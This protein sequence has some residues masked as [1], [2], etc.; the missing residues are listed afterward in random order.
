MA[1]L[2]E[3]LG[4]LF[5]LKRR[6]AEG[7]YEEQIREVRMVGTPGK[8]PRW[9]AKNQPQGY[10][11]GVTPGFA[12]FE[13]G[14][15]RLWYMGLARKITKAARLGFEFTEIDYEALSEM[16]E[17]NLADQ[18]KRIRE[19]EQIEFGLHMPVAARWGEVDLCL[20]DAFWWRFMHEAVRKSAWSAATFGSKFILF[21][22]SSRMRPNVTFKI[23]HR[24]APSPQVSHDGINLGQFM[25]EV[26][27]GTY[28]D[29]KR[30][31]VGAFPLKEWFMAKFMRV[32]F[33]AMGVAGDVGM[34]T[35]FEE[36][37]REKKMN[38]PEAKKEAERRY[39]DIRG[40]AWEK[41]KAE[42]IAVYN[43]EIAKSQAIIDTIEAKVPR[44]QWPG[45]HEYRS[46]KAEIASYQRLIDTLQ[47]TDRFENLSREI[48]VGNEYYLLHEALNFALNEGINPQVRVTPSYLEY[49]RYA[50]VKSY[51]ESHDFPRVYDY[52][53]TRM[54]SEAEEAV[55]YHVIAKFMYWTKDPLWMDIVGNYDPDDLKYSADR[56]EVMFQGKRVMDLIEK[57]IAAVAGKYIQGHYWVKKWGHGMQDFSEL[58]KKTELK[59]K[60]ISIIEFCR[61]NLIQIY[62]E[63]VQ[64]GEEVA[65]N[66]R[67][68][69]AIDHIKII[70]QLDP[71]W[72]SYTMD[73]EHLT[74]N[75]IRLDDH[76]GELEKMGKDV[77]KFIRMLHVNAP[78]PIAGTH[79]PI[80]VMSA[81][82][83]Q[84]YKWMHRLQKIGWKNAYII[85]EMGSF[86]I[87]QSGIAFKNLVEELK[88]GT[89][90][91]NLP[92]SFF[93]LGADFEAQQMV[94]VREHAWAPL[95]GLITVPEEEW[96]LLS[97][98]AT[99]KGR[100][101]VWRAGRF[102]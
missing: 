20:S 49:E 46:A 21:H 9:N 70:K 47:K 84:I 31:G 18:I 10:I 30:G 95:E 6:E 15:A 100:G 28:V 40:K 4:G 2:S 68:I 61:T 3:V 85:W 91:N 79:A 16:Y 51:T 22:T 98:A 37:S 41:A 101:E 90:P 97:R 96:T 56:D 87:D 69:S 43:S 32:L 80:Y 92:D 33:H 14:M 78:R 52:W 17:A 50:R 8:D 73:F 102:R 11:L 74:V 13:S 23:G 1:R 39:D 81:D 76:I 29:P 82:L 24:E 7:G 94:A 72:F 89:D 34:I 86:G 45:I 88:K 63:T 93:G 67:I 25:E 19:H 75:Y 35:F 54:G 66:V 83:L 44:E 42:R 99:E 65:G 58:Q 5:K 26:Q 12:S 64:P 27:S 38:Y 60:E 77:G 59:G 71:E 55:A 53:K 48:I 36:M 57:W 62:I